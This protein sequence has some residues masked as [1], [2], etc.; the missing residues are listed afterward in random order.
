MKHGGRSGAGQLLDAERHQVLQIAPGLPF[1]AVN[2]RGGDAAF[3]GPD[4]FGDDIL[5][6]AVVRLPRLDQTGLRGAGFGIIFL[7]G[8]AGDGDAHALDH[9][10]IEIRAGLQTPGSGYADLRLVLQLLLAAPVA[11]D[12]ILG[13][14]P[15]AVFAFHEHIASFP[16]REQFKKTFLK[17]KA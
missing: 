9:D 14:L 11:E 1:I 7:F 16:T 12:G 8:L 17:E 3:T 2:G 13:D 10:L 5:H 6:D 4:I 15:P